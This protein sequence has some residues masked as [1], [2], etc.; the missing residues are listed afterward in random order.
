MRDSKQ[1]LL[2]NMKRQVR[3]I[4]KTKKENQR[5]RIKDRKREKEKKEEKR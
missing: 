5:G 2:I 3:E 4:L 1:N